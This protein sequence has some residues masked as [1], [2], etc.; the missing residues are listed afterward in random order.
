MVD[1]RGTLT[2]AEAAVLTF[3]EAGPALLGPETAERTVH[4]RPRL[5][6]QPPLPQP[7]PPPSAL[8]RP[9]A[10]PGRPAPRPRPRRHR[11]RRHGP[12]R[13]PPPRQRPRGARLGA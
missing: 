10:R 1:H 4:R 12:D 7:A 3:L 8:R 6:D 5:Y 13:R 11:P 2:A 9:A